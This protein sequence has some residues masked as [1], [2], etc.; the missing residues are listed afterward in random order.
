MPLEILQSRRQHSRRYSWDSF[1]ELAE[2]SHIAHRNVS[3]DEH[4]PLFPEKAEAV[5]DWAVADRRVWNY[6]F[7]FLPYAR[8]RIRGLER[9]D[10][11]RLSSHPL[12]YTI[13]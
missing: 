3:Q 11:R 6:C 4:C 13:V 8:R 10:W 1:H 5:R 9:H 12:I 2:P 7:S